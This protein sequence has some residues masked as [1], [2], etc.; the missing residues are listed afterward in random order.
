MALLIL[1]FRGPFLLLRLCLLEW[2]VHLRNRSLSNNKAQGCLKRDI[3]TTRWLPVVSG[4]THLLRLGMNVL[5][6][7]ATGQWWASA[8]TCAVRLKPSVRLDS[9][10]SFSSPRLCDVGKW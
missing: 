1:F 4:R 7:P 5:W 10:S 6:F 8:H 9:H 2:K 3:C